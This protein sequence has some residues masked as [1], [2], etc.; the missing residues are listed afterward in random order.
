MTTAGE[1]TLQPAVSLPST[2]PSLSSTV[3]P[4]AADCL[5]GKGDPNLVAFCFHFALTAAKPSV[6][7]V[8]CMFYDRFRQRRT[9]WWSRRYYRLPTLF[10][11]LH[12]TPLFV[13]RAPTVTCTAFARRA[14]VVLLEAGHFMVA[15]VIQKGPNNKVSFKHVFIP[16]SSGHSEQ[17]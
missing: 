14:R 7:L 3:I 11:W 17:L 2:S 12:I 13:A 6:T 9:R 16:G 5:P 1:P 10:H 8:C 15:W 4:V